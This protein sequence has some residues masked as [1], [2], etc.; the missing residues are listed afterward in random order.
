MAEYQNIFTSVQ[1]RG[2]VYAGVPLPAGSW[3]RDGQPFFSYWLGRIGDAQVGPLY[4]GWTGVASLIFG[5]IAFEII[6]LNMWA[7]VNWDPIQFARQLP[8][9]ALEPPPPSYG[10]S[11]IHISEPTRRTPISYAVFCL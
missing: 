6:G 5:F 1:V 10:L 3:T 11:L 9:L 2:P 7:S 8:W 4:L